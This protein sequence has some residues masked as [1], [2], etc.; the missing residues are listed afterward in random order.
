MKQQRGKS[1]WLKY[2]WKLLCATEIHKDKCQMKT[3]AMGTGSFGQAGRKGLGEAQQQARLGQCVP[4]K[5]C[6]LEGHGH[7]GWGKEILEQLQGQA[8]ELKI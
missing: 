6:L 3:G 8:E 4:D 5:A 1:T 7:W 2:S